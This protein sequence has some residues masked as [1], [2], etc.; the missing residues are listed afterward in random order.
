ML[1]AGVRDGMCACAGI[2]FKA[3][4]QGTVF[5]HREKCVEIKSTML[6]EKKEHE[7]NSTLRST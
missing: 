7:M 5:I 4:K 3:K 6:D 1:H 2:I